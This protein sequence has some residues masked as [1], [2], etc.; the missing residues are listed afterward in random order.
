MYRVAFMYL[1]TMKHKS[2]NVLLNVSIIFCMFNLIMTLDSMHVN[3]TF[4]V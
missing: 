4:I 2:N 1:C 3:L